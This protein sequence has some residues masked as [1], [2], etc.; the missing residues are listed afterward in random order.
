MR[1]GRKRCE[2][3]NGQDKVEAKTE[4]KRFGGAPL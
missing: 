3:L 1:L 4:D 2:Q